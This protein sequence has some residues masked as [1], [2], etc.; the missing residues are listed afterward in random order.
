MAKAGELDE[1]EEV[2]H[3]M[4]PPLNVEQIQWI[5]REFAQATKSG[6]TITI[7]LSETEPMKDLIA[8]TVGLVEQ[9]ELAIGRLEH[10]DH[11]NTQ[12]LVA[13]DLR[14]ALSDFRVNGLGSL[15]RDDE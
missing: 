5:V 4:R 10:G 2:L 8:A 3:A 12:S 6:Y 11:L 13:D 14:D 7:E 9:I 15:E 1:L